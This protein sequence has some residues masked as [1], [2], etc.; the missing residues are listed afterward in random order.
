MYLQ[1][2]KLLY[3]I[4]IHTYLY[5]TKRKVRNSGRPYDWIDDPEINRK[6]TKEGQPVRRL[7]QLITKRA[8]ARYGYVQY[9][10]VAQGKWVAKVEYY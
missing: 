4:L 6:A 8:L 10:Y 9:L 5:N 2:Y 7:V 1:S 3:G